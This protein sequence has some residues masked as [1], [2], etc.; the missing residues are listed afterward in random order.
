MSGLT[1]DQSKDKDKVFGEI[2]LRYKTESEY[3]NWTITN[4]TFKPEPAAA[5]IFYGNLKTGG[6]VGIR[7]KYYK[8]EDGFKVS[9]FGDKADGGLTEMDDVG[10]LPGS[11][12][13]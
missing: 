7:V 4:F 5:A 6:N 9:L 3:N 13:T 10:S 8:D 2:K 12:A 11:P 1:I